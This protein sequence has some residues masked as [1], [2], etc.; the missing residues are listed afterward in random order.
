MGRP[1]KNRGQH[2]G[3]GA[4]VPR[5]KKLFV[6]IF[7][8]ALSVCLASSELGELASLLDDTSNDFVA[9]PTLGDHLAELAIAKP[10]PSVEPRQKAPRT[11]TLDPASLL[12]A[13]PIAA[14]A[15]DPLQFS[16]IRR[17]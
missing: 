16:T 15:L 13:R 11:A 2:T 5:S 12:P 9:Q 7:F 10:V 8:C 4:I 17:T 1:T 3:L 14:T 6:A